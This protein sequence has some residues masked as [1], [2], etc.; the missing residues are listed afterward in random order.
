MYP[1]T[2]YVFL[3]NNN[4]Y[5]TN[6]DKSHLFDKKERKTEKLRY[7][8]KEGGIQRTRD[9]DKKKERQA[10]FIVLLS[11]IDASEITRLHVLCNSLS[12]SSQLSLHNSST[13][14]T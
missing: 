5:L 7:R 6:T 12:M 4:L 3:Y 14:G 2:S 10:S 8:R 1:R 9:I 13:A 11:A